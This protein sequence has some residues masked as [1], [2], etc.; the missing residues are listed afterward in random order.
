[1]PDLRPHRPA[2]ATAR[3][4]TLVP[5][6]APV[7][8]PPAPDTAPATGR[9]RSIVE[10]LAWLATGEPVRLKWLELVPALAAMTLFC[11]GIAMIAARLT[12]HIRDITQLIPFLTRLVFYLSGIFYKSPGAGA[13]GGQ[14]VLATVLEFNPVHVYISLVRGAVIVGENAPAHTWRLGIGFGV[15]FFLMGFVYFWLAEERYGRE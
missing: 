11:T 6:P 7:E 15:V 10:R 2:P 14:S 4:D 12:I 13:K 3:L 5:P 1:M 8:R 9:L